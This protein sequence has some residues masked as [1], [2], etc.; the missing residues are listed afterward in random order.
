MLM[1]FAVNVIHARPDSLTVVVNPHRGLKSM[2]SA[3]LRAIFKGEKPRWQNGEKVVIALMKTSTPTGAMTAEKLYKMTVD[4]LNRYWVAM[5]FRGQAKAPKSFDS[6]EELLKFVAKTRGAIGVVSSAAAD[7]T[8]VP[9][10][11]DGKTAW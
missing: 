2:R 8:I 1:L 5:V 10:V 7:T 3:E 6:E 11:V 9:I 4:E